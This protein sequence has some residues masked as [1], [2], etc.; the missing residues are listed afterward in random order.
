MSDLY[1]ILRTA[2][3]YGASDI[4]LSCGSHPALKINGSLVLINQLPEI[5]EQDFDE[6]MKILAKKEDIE[7]F[8]EKKDNDFSTEIE[9][10]GRFRVNLF[11]QSK[12]PSAAIR[13]IPEEVQSLEELNLP[14]QLDSL[15][16]LKSG[17]VLVTGPAGVGK[18]TTIASMLNH[19]N[20]K[21]S[22]HIITIEDPIEFTFQNQKSLIEQREVRSHSE[23]FTTAL[24]AALR[25][26]PDIILVGELRDLETISLA[27]TA[28]ET[29]HLVFATV[30]TSGAP[31]TID[32]LI[33]VFPS[34]QQSQVKTQLAM[35]LQA[36]IWQKLVR[37][38]DGEHRIPA[39]EILMKNNAT[40]N[41]IRKGATHQV[42]SMMET[43]ASEGMQT[44]TYA[45]NTL[46]SQ[47]KITER[48]AREH[49]GEIFHEDE[50]PFQI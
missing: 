46:V 17:L 44:M 26:A 21:Q 2:V 40:A 48:E 32:R 49:L 39:C 28:A 27:I 18:S 16:K 13:P 47:G 12:G 33:D 7:Q 20:T 3:E 38:S 11:M 25:E 22:K 50:N 9:N 34:E 37:T 31:Q 1:K 23:S 30:H 45:L 36:I 42:H 15:C 10:I 19:I 14:R 5:S 43:S 4:F 41:L 24:R 6:Y 8:Q 35:S 29:G